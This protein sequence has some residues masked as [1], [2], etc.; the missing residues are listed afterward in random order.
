MKYD[1]EEVEHN[2]IGAY[3][4]NE[5]L[6]SKCEHLIAESLFSNKVNRIVFKAIKLLRSK[7]VRPDHVTLTR[8]IKGAFLD[9]KVPQYSAESNY[10]FQPIPYVQFLFEENRIKKHLNPHI[11][12]AHKSFTSGIGSPLDIMLGLKEKINDVEMVLNNVSAEKSIG[13][14]VD[15]AIEE[16][17]E[18]G[19]D[20]HSSAPSTSLKGVDSITGGLLPGIF[21]IGALPGMGKTSFIVNIMVHNAIKLKVP[22]VFFSLEMS[23][24]QIVKNVVANMHEINTMAIRDGNLSEEEKIRFKS[25]RPA[26]KDNLIIDDTPGVTWQYIDAKLTKIR[27]KFP[28]GQQIIVMVDYLQLMSNTEDE[29]KGKTDEAQMALRCKGLMNMWKKHNASLSSHN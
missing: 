27:K 7:G 10:K 24:T 29:I 6:F 11:Y 13:E 21:V 9:I 25:I 19:E 14:I 8:E 22:V 18:S 5:D 20:N 2:L 17:M 28:I 4:E 3:I 26:F 12:E 15:K 23:A 1:I 16:V